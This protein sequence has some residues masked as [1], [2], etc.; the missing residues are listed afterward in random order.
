MKKIF[1]TLALFGLASSLTFAQK[2]VDL[3]LVSFDEPAMNSQVPNLASGE[4]IQFVVTVVNNGPDVIAAED[5]LFL[6]F[7]GT[8]IA[9]DG[10]N[11]YTLY[12]PAFT[13]QAVAVGESVQLAMEFT[14]GDNYGDAGNGPVIT[15]FPQDAADTIATW[16]YGKDQY[17]DFFDDAG[18]SPN[19]SGSMMS[20]DDASSNNLG[21]TVFTFGDPN[22]NTGIKDIDNSKNALVVYPNPA[23]TSISVKYN[24][25]QAA[26]ASVRVM[27]IFGR[28][29]INNALGFQTVG[30]KEFNVN[31][32]GLAQGLYTIEISTEN[33]RATN[34]F[35]IVK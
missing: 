14:Q 16:V 13:G 9:T 3:E 5:T 1:S 2:N 20:P 27:D 25:E 11:D 35:S 4:S 32:N 18:V 12:A 15:N 6:A 29:V 8:G 17:G 21:V 26:T 23:N 10:T 34:R 7:Q 19:Q 31:L 22:N 24:F 30:E 28:T 33:G